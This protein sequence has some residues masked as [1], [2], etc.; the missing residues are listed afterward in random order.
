MDRTSPFS[1]LCQ[2]CGRCCH[3]QV[4]TLSPYDVIRIARAAGIPTSGAVAK[5]TIRRGSVLRFDQNGA[6][7]ALQGTTCTI[8]PGRPLACR[9]YPLGMERDGRGG[10]TYLRLQPASGSRGI[11]G[12]DDASVDDF[13]TAQG[14]ED[15]L[16]AMRGYASLL[17]VC[18]DRIGQLIDF[19]LLEPREFWRVA[20]RE[21]LAESGFDRNHLVE[22]LFDPDA[23]RLA[24]SFD[25]ETVQQHVREL[26]RLIR[27][28]NNAN[29]VATAAALLAV[30]LGYSP[31]EIIVGVESSQRHAP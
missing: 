10:E 11:Y 6:C 31:G 7:V 22:A 20:V 18:V 16:T 28:E 4:I 23:L 27:A 14:T 25:G 13:L 19:E 26:K 5:Y 8:H 21:A 24:A 3:D 9:I 29:I 1:Y 30:S 2:R 12:G 17:D 15:Y